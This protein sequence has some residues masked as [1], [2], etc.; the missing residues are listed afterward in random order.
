M[1][2]MT[3]E[4]LAAIFAPPLRNSGLIPAQALPAAAFMLLWAGTSLERQFLPPFH[5]VPVDQLQATRHQAMAD[6]DLHDYSGKIDAS[7]RSFGYQAIEQFRNAIWIAQEDGA[8]PGEMAE[9]LLGWGAGFWMSSEGAE[10][11]AAL[12]RG[13][14]H[15]A[16]TIRCAFSLAARPAWDLAKNSPVALSVENDEIAETLSILAQ[17]SR[18]PITIEARPMDGLPREAMKP[19]ESERALIIPPLGMRT[20]LDVRALNYPGARPGEPVSSEAYATLWGPQLADGRSLVVVGNGFL[21]R[22]NSKDAAL[23]QELVEGGRLSA[24]IKLP[25]GSY[26]GSNV[27]VSALVFES[28]GASGSQPGI[29]FVDATTKGLRDTALVQKLLMTREPHPDCALVSWA[30]IRE[31]GFNLSVERYVL[32]AETRQSRNLLESRETVRLADLA[33]IHRSQALPRGM[34]DGNTIAIREVMLADIEDGH[35]LLPQKT[36][37]VPATATRKIESAVLKAGDVLLSIKGTI[38]KV[39]LVSE[40]VLSE[41]NALIIPGQ[42]LV[43]IRLRKNSPIRSPEVLARYL[44]SAAIQSLLQRMAGGTTIANVAMGELKDLPV[45]V[46]DDSTQQAVLRLSDE[47]NSFREAIKSLRE[48]IEDKNSDIQELIF[49]S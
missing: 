10:L 20:N 23:K 1:R 24:I 9:A 41:S 31:T 4:M 12:L 21:F 37:E 3:P 30:E 8:A 18:L 14:G 33:E 16:P 42:S 19:P 5:D 6:L 34:D 49:S 36:S 17:A 26:P 44:G 11:L 27:A 38:G 32:D 46:L 15:H 2:T 39:G 48:K 13:E 22:T 45:P 25:R 29:Y 40:A 7:W 43:I 47:Q 35:L 28:E